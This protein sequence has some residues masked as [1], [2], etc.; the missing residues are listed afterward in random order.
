M[1]KIGVTRIDALGSLRRCVSTIGDIDIAVATNKPKEVIAH[2]LTYPHKEII[3]E[4][5]TGAD[6]DPEHRLGGAPPFAILPMIRISST[7]SG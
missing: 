3:E 2:F 5:P 7:T 1:K 4:G 6:R